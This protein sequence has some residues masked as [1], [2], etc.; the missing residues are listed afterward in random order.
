MHALGVKELSEL[1]QIPNGHV[2]SACKRIVKGNIDGSVA[3]FHIKYPR[4]PAQFA[5]TTNN[6]QSVVTSCHQASQ[7]NSSDFEISRYGNRF[8]NDWCS[9]YSGNDYRLAI[10]E[11]GPG[12]IAIRLSNRLNQF[13]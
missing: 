6:S 7:I 9:E 1:G 11:I 10:F 4:I 8:F 5:P 12:K 3:I 13:C 2:V